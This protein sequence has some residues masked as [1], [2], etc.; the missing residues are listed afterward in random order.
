MFQKINWES[1]IV[2]RSDRD[3][4]QLNE[5]V[6]DVV[7]EVRMAG[8]SEPENASASNT[9]GTGCQFSFLDPCVTENRQ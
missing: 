4:D 9:S 6:N 8:V 3:T 7:L 1:R 5:A 2:E